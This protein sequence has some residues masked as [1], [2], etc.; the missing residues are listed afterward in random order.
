MGS[1]GKGLGIVALI[2]AIGALG[3]GVYQTFL[4]PRPLVEHQGP[5][6]HQVHFNLILLWVAGEV[7]PQ[8][9]HIIPNR[10]IWCS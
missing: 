4:H 9:L 7:F 1:S 6:S 2:L 10:A 3:L 5:I 8:L